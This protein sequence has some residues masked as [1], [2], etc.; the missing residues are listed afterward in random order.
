MADVKYTP[1]KNN[2]NFMVNNTKKQEEIKFTIEISKN[3][4]YMLEKI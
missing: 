3:K 1:M 2:P 4:S